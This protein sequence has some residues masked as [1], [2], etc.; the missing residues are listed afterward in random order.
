MKE[1]SIYDKKS[2]RTVVG[3]NADFNE[4]AKDCV[5]FSNAEGGS[6][7]IGIEDDQT[8]PPEKQKI[9]DGLATEIV[10]KVTGK[11]QGVV[12]S[13]E[14]L[15][16]E[17]GGEFIKLHVLR[18]A[19]SPSAT[20]SGKFFLRIG[21]NSVPVGPEDIS[22]LAEDKGCISWE[23]T[24]TK[25]SWRDADPE[26]LASFIKLLKKSD[27]VSNFVKQKETK[28]I[29]DFYYLTDPD[30][31]KMTNL[32]VLFIGKQT[33][34]GRIQNAPVIQCIK[35]DQNGEKVNKWL[36]DDYTMNPYEMINSVWELVPEWKESSEITEGMF[37]RNI[38]AYP[39]KVVREL[40]SNS[41]VHRPYTVRGDIFIN[42]HPDHIDVVNPGRLPL[43]VTVKN[44]LHTTKKRNEHMAAVFYALHLMEREGSGY[45]MMYETLLANGKPIPVVTEGDDSVSVRVDRRIINEEVIK[46]MQHADQRYDVKQKQ[47][48]CLGL[49]ALHE[50]LTATEL[51]RI[52]NLKDADELRSWLRLLIDKELV[53][54]TSVHS[55]SKEYQ[56]NPLLLK[57]SQFMGKTSLKRIEDYRIKE[58]IKEDLK[59]YKVATAA[60]IQ[61]RI[62]EEI[63]S[64]K[65]WKQL[66]ALVKEGHIRKLGSNRWLKYELVE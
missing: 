11:T 27:R 29:L 41:L 23:D 15:V 36:W 1:N 38:L 46:V 59:I 25:Y 64:K 58:L 48:I 42:I 20:T 30:S 44:I 2:L 6:I 24:E 39:E 7:D 8:L 51:I 28:E 40:L 63:P 53:I 65:I 17:N 45:D 10:N 3:K 14:T 34:R 62:G 61:K 52:L 22:R 16:A 57:S 35:Y 19:N 50:S 18:N 4:L 54:G 31:D 47:L 33:Q 5:A 49:I 9:P 56:V 60:E 26:K 66:Q 43:G 55:K 13:A 32:G 37:R 21:D 12:L